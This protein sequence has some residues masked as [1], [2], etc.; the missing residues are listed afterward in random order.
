VYD[1]KKGFIRKHKNISLNDG[2]T[3][4]ITTHRTPTR[5][6]E[7]RNSR[8]KRKNIKRRKQEKTA[9]ITYIRSTHTEKSGRRPREE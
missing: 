1:D 7:N 2:K 4:I 3:S 8:G 9:T 5:K 6:K